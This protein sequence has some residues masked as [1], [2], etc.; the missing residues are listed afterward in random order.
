MKVKL[1]F[2]AAVGVLTVAGLA[3]AL[4]AGVPAVAQAGGAPS[5][6][7]ASVVSSAPSST[8][9]STPSSTASSSP[10][11]APS[12]TPSPHPSAT[13]G[14]F[15]LQATGTPAKGPEGTTWVLRAELK[16]PAGQTP[17]SCQ[18]VVWTIS[19]GTTATG[20]IA[21]VLMPKKGT[22]TASATCTTA[23]GKT[24]TSNRVTI[25]VTAPPGYVTLKKLKTKVA[26]V[27][28]FAPVFG[29]PKR[30][31]K[32]GYNWTGYIYAAGSRINPTPASGVSNGPVGPVLT[33][34]KPLPPGDYILYVEVRQ[35][36][37]TVVIGTGQIEFSVPAPAP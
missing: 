16:G 20:E 9:S 26:G 36:G 28:R 7:P 4:A 17:P 34:D 37:S 19:D 21:G 5:G 22:Y 23:D 2:G 14:P 1:A 29:N 32:G 31:Y 30:G 35:I 8:V 25:T 12:S 3:T 18:R 10:S 13:E 15:T 6:Q 24:Y 11:S 33:P 27:P